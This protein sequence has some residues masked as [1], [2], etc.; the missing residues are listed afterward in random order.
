MG[1]SNLE[2]KLTELL[3]LKLVKWKSVPTR[4]QEL[5]RIKEDISFSKEQEEFKDFKRLVKALDH[6]TR[7]DILIS[8]NNGASCPCELEFITELSQA[9]VSHHLTILEDAGIVS[10][11]RKGKWTILKSE[12]PNILNSFSHQ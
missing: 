5:K 4:I 10:R 1:D 8:I 6:P 3:D 9:T 11:G 12:K 7:L 2:R